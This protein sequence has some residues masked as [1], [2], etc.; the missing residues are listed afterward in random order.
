[1]SDDTE[2]FAFRM[3]LAEGRVESYRKRHDEIWPEL[4]AALHAAGVLEYR[5]FHQPGTSDLFAVM[6]RRKAHG[7]A[8]L[9]ASPLMRRWWDMMADVTLTGVDGVPVQKELVAGLRDETARLSEASWRSLSLRLGLWLIGNIQETPD[10]TLAYC[11]HPG[12]M[13]Q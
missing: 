4:E 8:A 5:I 2:V 13:P 12:P 9:A 1:M 10:P 6:R 7:L 3:S 11:P